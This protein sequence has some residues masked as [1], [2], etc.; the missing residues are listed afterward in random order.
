MAMFFGKVLG[1]SGMIQRVLRFKKKEDLTF[2]CGLLS[3]AIALKFYNESLF[4]SKFKGIEDVNIWYTIFAGFLVGF[5]A[6]MAN[7]CTSGHMLCGCSRL[8]IRSIAA[9]AIFCF[10]AIVSRRLVNLEQTVYKQEE[11][12]SPAIPL[13]LYFALSLTILLMTTLALKYQII[14]DFVRFICGVMFALGLGFSGMTKSEKVLGFLDIGTSNFDPAL[15]M[16]V[17]GGVLPNVFLNRLVVSKAKKPLFAT[18]FDFPTNKAIDKKLLLG[19]AVFGFGWGICGVCPG[20]A[21]TLLSTSQLA[22]YLFVASM[23]S[24]VSINL[25]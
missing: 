4:Y 20:P 22:P 7:G 8:S 6:K 17:L 23:F 11:Y 16:V 18:E 24:G 25:Q 5:G 14:K 10:S 1:V 21:L 12:L 19:S 13:S 2:L 3:G 15:L 9:S